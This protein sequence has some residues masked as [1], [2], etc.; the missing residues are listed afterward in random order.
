[1]RREK[2]RGLGDEVHLIAK[3]SYEK[4]PAD[5]GNLWTKGRHLR[6]TISRAVCAFD[7][8]YYFQW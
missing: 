3:V 7:M 8:H 6:N 2:N 1:M 4:T 5:K